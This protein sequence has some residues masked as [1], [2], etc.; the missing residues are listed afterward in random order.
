ME[1]LAKFMR[2]YKGVLVCYYNNSFYILFGYS[3]FYH[4]FNMG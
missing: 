3:L 2:C 4:K 1:I